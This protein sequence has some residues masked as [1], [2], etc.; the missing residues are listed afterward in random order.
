MLY[1]LN[2]GVRYELSLTAHCIR[3]LIAYSGLPLSASSVPAAW[4]STCNVLL[5]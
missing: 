5:R 2:T 3:A 1:Q 4:S